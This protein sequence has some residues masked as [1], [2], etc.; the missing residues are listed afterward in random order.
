MARR[1]QPSAQT[2][3]KNT[4][5]VVQPFT[6]ATANTPLSQAEALNMTYPYLW[7]HDEDD[8]LMDAFDK[9]KDASLDIYNT[10]YIIE[11]MTMHGRNDWER[12]DSAI[13]TTPWDDSDMISSYFNESV[14]VE[15]KRADEKYSPKEY[16]DKHK[17]ALVASAHIL[18]ASSLNTAVWTNIKGCGMFRSFLM[19]GWIKAKAAKSVLDFSAGWMDRLIGALAVPGVRYVGVDPNIRLVP[20]FKAIVSQFATDPSLYTLVSE[21]FQTARLPVNET[22]DLV[23]TSPPYFGL[24]VYSDDVTQSYSRDMSVDDWLVTFLFPSLDK[25]WGVLND[26]GTMCII[27]N[28]TKYGHYVNTMIQYMKGMTSQPVVMIPYIGGAQQAQPMWVWTKGP[29]VHAENTLNPPVSVEDYTT[30]SGT[31]VSVVRDDL[32]IGGTKQRALIPY[33]ETIDTHEVVY[34]G[35]DTGYAQLALAYVCPLIG[36][37]AVLFLQGLDF[38][39]TSPLTEQAVKYGAI[40]HMMPAKLSVVE[41]EARKYDARTPDST[42]LRLGMSDPIYH[43]MLV[44]ALRAAMPLL[45]PKRVWAAVGSMALMRVLARVWPE[46]HFMAVQVG[47]D[48]SANIPHYLKDRVTVIEVTKYKFRQA[49]PADEMP[50]YPSLASYDAKV[51]SYVNAQARPGDYVWNVGA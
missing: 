2:V 1:A 13:A 36:K 9:L 8:R 32:L 38:V 49:V 50:P 11:N 51:W 25:A 4:V 16:W 41:A 47:R 39:P 14:R 21:P 3:I 44:K 24:E 7:G 15:C 27:I 18:T 17:R 37:Q 43:W 20:S 33:L 5:G 19:T 46:A 26:G 22:Y 35:P 30:S 45:S 23:F 34:A 40:V 28:D 6:P 48:V 42:R 12:N 10:D 31:I 29:F